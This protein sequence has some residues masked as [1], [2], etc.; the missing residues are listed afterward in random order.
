MLELLEKLN[1]LGPNPSPD[2]AVAAISPCEWSAEEFLSVPESQDTFL[3]REIYLDLHKGHYWGPFNRG[4]FE[5][6]NLA[7]LSTWSNARRLCENVPHRIR[8]ERA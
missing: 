6:R 1:K 4:Y 3:I 7:G 2:E 5:D 8:I